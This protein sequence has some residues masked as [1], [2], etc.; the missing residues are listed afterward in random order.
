ML[1]Q[2]PTHPVEIDLV[3]LNKAQEEDRQSLLLA[4]NDKH[5]LKQ[6]KKMLAKKAKKMLKHKKNNPDAVKQVFVLDFEGDTKASQVAFLR[7]QIS[8]IVD[9]ASDQDEVVLRL[10]SAGGIVHLYGLAA[11]QLV[12]LKEAGIKLS[13]CVDEVAASGGYLMAVVADQILAAPFAVVGSIGVVSG[14]PNFHRLLERY[15]VDYELFT[16]G[17]YKR[18]VTMLG[19]NDEQG[20]EKYQQEL[21]Q[22]H[23][24]FQNFVAKYRPN[25]D[26]QKVATGEHWY[27]QDALALNLVDKLQTSDAYLLELMQNHE[28]Y[29]LYFRHKPSLLEK[30]GLVDSANQISSQL[31]QGAFNALGERLARHSLKDR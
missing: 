13:I 6:V 26:L 29:A 8:L 30:L 15:D 25:L 21:E 10:N 3:H 18:T 5:K 31:V 17:Q 2:S 4:M 27:A 11:A 16:A 7:E 22:V 9:L 12:R 20:R 28:V 1:F 23:Q 19:K 14:L 24:L